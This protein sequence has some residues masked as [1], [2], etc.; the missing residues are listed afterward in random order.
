MKTRLGLYKRGR[1]FYID[2]RVRGQRYIECF[3]PVSRQF[4]QEMAMKR[5]TELYEGKL[6]FPVKDPPFSVFIDRHV[7]DVSGDNARDR[8]SARNLKAFLGDRPVLQISRMDVEQYKRVRRD[9]VEAKKGEGASCASVNR[10]LALLSH[11]LNVERLPNPTRG[12]KRFEESS[13]ERILDSEEEARMFAA[14]GDLYPDLEPFFRVLLNA[15]YRRGEVL[16]LRNDR[17]MI[18]FKEG[19]IRIPREIR[20]GKRKEVVTPMNGVLSRALREAIKVNQVGPGER[21]FPY[22]G[23]WV[24]KRWDRIRRRAGLEGVRIHDLRHTFG[25]RAGA[26]AHDDPYAVQELMGHT[27]FRTTQKYIHVDMTRKRVL[28]DR[29]DQDPAKSPDTGEEGA[30]LVV[31]Q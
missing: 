22:P 31:V 15:G 3:G 8:L 6:R 20:K 26:K 4:A 29:L 13:R 21:I 18:N 5:R 23:H 14:I 24:S 9:Q 1:S 19:F 12:V 28:M 10:E 7:R 30:R 16:A 27:D 25:S 17:E 11:A 2:I